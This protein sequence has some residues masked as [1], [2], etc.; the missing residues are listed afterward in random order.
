[1]T[2]AGSS[3]HGAD[4]TSAIAD[5]LATVLPGAH[6]S[7]RSPPVDPRWL[8]DHVAHQRVSGL[9]MLALD[10]GAGGVRSA[11]ISE[12]LEPV[13][14]EALRTSL[15]A[16]AASV[17]VHE[18]FDAAG[19]AHAVLKGCA[20]A[21]L[22]YADPAQRITGDLDV[23]IAR[24]DYDVALAAL[25]GSGL[26]RVEPPFRER[27][28]RRYA[29]DIALIGDGRVEVDLHLA[30]SAGY[31]G[32]TMPVERLLDHLETYRVAGRSLPALDLPGRLMHAAIHTAGST[33]V[34]LGS[35]ADVILISARDDF[36]LDVFVQRA[37]ELRCD[38]LV[39][40]GVERAWSTFD[41]APT[42]LSEWAVRHRPEGGQ[43]RALQAMAGSTGEPRWLAGAGALPWRR[44][45]GYVLPLVV[46]SREYLTHRG[47]SRGE[48]LRTSI[49]RLRAS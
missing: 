37:Y 4:P 39:A 31:F 30:L 36:A 49:R 6:G 26:R 2:A 21:Q 42:P 15:A 29:K 16:E 38:A 20:T 27:W 8:V 14:L 25:T 10:A 46:P 48:H 18:L 5:L 32:V 17:E 47:R 13:H 41:V 22:D 43:R 1:M 44:R 11:E 40:C 33:P 9:A 3:D 23:L 24:S 34:R 45:L 35:C 7:V 19:V 28:E 12:L